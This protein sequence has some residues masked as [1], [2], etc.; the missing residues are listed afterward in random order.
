[1]F[2]KLI[3]KFLYKKKWLHQS[4]I[5]KEL[6][7]DNILN[8]FLNFFLNCKNKINII[9]IGANDGKT[10]DPIYESLEK[11]KEKI[12]LICFEP[13][14]EAFSRLKENYKNFKNVT[15]INKAIGKHGNQNFYYIAWF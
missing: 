2:K 6:R 3:K 15:L 13:Q 7:Q 11:F 9:Q 8:F 4:D 12:N 5:Y 10:N 14:K 1:M